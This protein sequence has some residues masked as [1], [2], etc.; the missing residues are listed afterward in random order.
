MALPAV[1][2]RVTDISVVPSG[3]QTQVTI[4]ADGT[5]AYDKFLLTDPM[6][7]VLDLSD[8]VHALPATDF[9]VARGG[10]A[11]IRTSQY[12]APPDGI[13]RVIVD[14]SGELM[15]YA[16]ESSGNT[17]VL[18]MQTQPS[19]TPFTAWSASAQQVQPVVSGGNVPPLTSP[20]SM[21][22]SSGYVYSSTQG[23][24]VSDAYREI[25]DGFPVEWTGSGGRRITID[26]VDADIRTVMRSISDVSG[27]NIILPEDY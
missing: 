11:A 15:N 21:V 25:D 20:S 18:T 9:T 5:I 1:A 16:T 27:M 22:T 19:G 3:D 14:V 7:V 24:Q 4:T 10:V 2:Y 12:K 8:A 6:R 26:V 17:L 13:V 23:I